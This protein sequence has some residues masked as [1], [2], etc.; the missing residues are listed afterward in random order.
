MKNTPGVHICF[1]LGMLLWPLSLFLLF[2]QMQTQGEKKLLLHCSVIHHE[3][4]YVYL[5][6]T[7]YCISISIKNR[8]NKIWCQTL[9]LCCP[10]AQIPFWTMSHFSVTASLH[11]FVSL[12]PLYCRQQYGL[13][14]GQSLRNTMLHNCMEPGVGLNPCGSLPT[15]DILYFPRLLVFFSV[16]SKQTL[17]AG[18]RNKCSF[19]PA[20]YK[21]LFATSHMRSEVACKKIS[22]P[23]FIVKYSREKTTQLKRTSH[24][25]EQCLP[26]H[27]QRINHALQVALLMK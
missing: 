11:G 14:I 23:V 13:L 5:N 25:S 9:V 2:S 17:P 18:V 27:N 15:W 3:L 22:R 1:F 12:P 26:L 10:R 24:L 19:M 8:A 16:R 4:K 20:F 7:M 21:Y 6:A